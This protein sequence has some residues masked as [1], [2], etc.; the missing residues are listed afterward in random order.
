MCSWR[1]TKYN[2]KDRNK[3]GSFLQESWTSFSDIGRDIN[4]SKLTL[5]EYMQ[6]ED[7]YVQA[8]KYFFKSVKSLP[9]KFCDFEPNDSVEDLEDAQ[10]TYPALYPRELLSLFTKL[11]D[12]YLFN[13]DEITHLCRLI[14]REHIWGKIIYEDDSH[15]MFAHF[16]YDYYM[17]LGGNIN[18][19]QVMKNIKKTGLYI[20]SYCSPYLMMY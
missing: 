13:Y 5:N 2:P 4:G 1:I 6:V 3:D 20:E 8:V 15:K 11:K 10:T 18:D 17:Y 19:D 14:L 9:L 7:A 16:G 12:G